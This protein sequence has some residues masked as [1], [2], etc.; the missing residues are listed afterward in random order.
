MGPP[1]KLEK[2][3]VV[4]LPTTTIPSY[5]QTVVGRYSPISDEVEEFRGIPYARVPGR[6]EHSHPR[7]QLPR[8]IFD[9]TE[10]GPRCPA[11]SPGDSRSFQSFLPYPNDRED[12]FECLNLLV[13]RPSPLELAKYAK[14]AKLPVLIWIHGGGFADG[15]ATNPPWDPARLVLRALKR[16]SPFIAVAINYR[17]NIFGF[18]ASSDM[19]IGQDDH[20][21]IKGVNFGL[22]DQ[23]LALIWVQRNIAS[24]GGDETKVTIMGHS[25][26]GVSCHVHLLE[27]ELGTKRPL[28]H[29]AGLLSGAWGGLDF[30]TMEKADEWWTDLCRFW[31]VQCESP[32]DRLNMLKRIPVKDLLHSVSELHWRFFILVIDQLTIIHSN[33]DCGVSFHLGH[34]ELITQAKAP[35]TQIQ[36][37]LGAT[38]EEFDGFVRLANWDYAKFCSIFIPSYPSE[39]AAHSV[40]QAYNIL[41]TSSETELFG[42]F[43]QFISDA[44]M[45]HR[46]YRA[47]EFLKAYRKDQA[48][49]SGR[50]SDGEG[51]QYYHVEF[52]NPFLGPSHDIAHHGVEL[53]YAFGNFQHALQKADRGILDGYNELQPAAV[54]EHQPL[55][56]MHKVTA[57]EVEETDL[58]HI[59]LSRAIQDRFIDFI[60]EDS[61]QTARRA[62][63]DIIT[64]YRHDRSI[65]LESWTDSENWARR[66]QRY[67]VL[68][69]DMNSMLVATRRLVGSVLTMSLE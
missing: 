48:L 67:D 54:P 27:A 20:A 4:L 16:K 15:A 9:A 44:T 68:E 64:T 6:W 55:A 35:D 30:R 34:D 63:S 40:L 24:F 58:S 60:V 39:A 43:V 13:V 14:S 23:R 22:H 25:A 26:G 29:K 19:L 36:V 45:M 65:R 8:D 61:W 7:E 32:I 51:V 3:P 2:L 66:R 10:N 21:A 47:G 42:A 1:L 12:E 46:V 5:L 33:L 53:I 59:D 57:S 50:K 62:N 49:L 31:S 17:L 41:P 56:E 28:F 37:M 52:G 38:A 69:Q 18:G 11:P